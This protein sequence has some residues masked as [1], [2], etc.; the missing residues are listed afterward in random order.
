MDSFPLI[1]FNNSATMNIILYAFVCINAKY[2]F[3][4]QMPKS[5][6]LNRR[7]TYLILH[8]LDLFLCLVVFPSFL[9]IGKSSLYILK[10]NL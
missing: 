4:T 6:S 2:F 3:S 5:R 8:I 1:F 7:Y 10:N 9:C